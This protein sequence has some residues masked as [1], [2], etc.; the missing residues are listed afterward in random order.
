MSKRAA[1]VVGLRG[2]FLFLELTTIL[3]NIKSPEDLKNVSEEKLPELAKEIR[4]KIIETVA[5]NGGHLASN[6]GVVELT[7]ALHRVFESPKD[8]LIFDVSHQCYAHKL[9]TGRY[10]NFDTLRLKGGISGFT[11]ESESVHDFFDNGHSSTSISQGLGLLTAWDRLHRDGKV[12]VVIGDGALTGGMAFEALSHAGQIQKNLIVILNDNQMSISPNTGSLSRY[13]STLT[14]T[15]FYQKFRCTIDAIVDKIPYSEHHIG[16]LI[17]RF[18]RA[19]KALFLDKNLFTDLGFEYVGPLDGHNIRELEENLRR[20]RKLS[21]PVV[22][23]IHTKKGRGY[24]PAENN[25][26]AFHGVGPFQISDGKMEKFDAL[27]FTESFNHSLMKIS[28]KNERIAAITAAMSKG[29]GLDTFARHHPERFF[30]VGIAEEHAVTFAAGLAKGGM[31]PVVAIYS[32]FIQRAID[33]IIHDVALSKKGVVFVFD[34][35]G[36]VPNDG[37]THQGLFDISLLRPVPNMT[38]LAPV[39]SRDLELC[40]EWAVE[41][42]S[43]VAIRYPKSSCPSE[44][45]S[46]SSEIQVGRGILIK[47]EEFAPSLSVQFEDSKKSF[48]KVLLVCTGGIFGETLIAARSL[49]QENFYA[50]IY[51]L[52]FLKPLD[53]S[54]FVSL[55]TSYDAVVFVEDGVKIGG[56]SEYLEN[57]LYRNN[58]TNVAIKA[59][60]DLFLSHG[61]R[62]Q[63]CEECGMLPKDIATAVK[64]LFKNTI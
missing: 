7:I 21:Q 36:V 63:I 37:E 11:R 17:F 2:L 54:Y 43:P 10:S 24:Y 30:D 35:S 16:K 34:R 23:H 41:S 53:E 13:L 61:S 15:S 44:F 22:V 64:K 42:S 1:R 38:L 6:L 40:L 18:K 45:P 14:M 27:S 60:P 50:D 59:F 19:I 58:F 32:T 31:I 47:N 39:S 62:S 3:S 57:L 56:I 25:P 49:L 48:K 9:L 28:E 4:K 26:A 52:R 12:V 33:Q 46:F 55:A 20:V 5:K 8:A 29:T 51:S